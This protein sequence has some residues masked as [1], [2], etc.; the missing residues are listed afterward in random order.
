MYYHYFK[1]RPLLTTYFLVFTSF[2]HMRAEMSCEGNHKTY[3]ATLVC[4]LGTLE[5]KRHYQSDKRVNSLFI[6]NL[7]L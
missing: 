6:F 3:S 7:K 4:Y 2:Y 1:T 5:K